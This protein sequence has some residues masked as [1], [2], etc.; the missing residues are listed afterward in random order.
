VESVDQTLPLW[1]YK[2]E[3][4]ALVLEDS[5]EPVAL[6]FSGG[7]IWTKNPTEATI[8]Q[9]LL[10]AEH[11]K[12][13]VRGDEFETYRTPTD[14]YLHP[15]DAEKY[16]KSRKEVERIIRSTRIKSFVFHSAVFGF[17]M[18]LILL[19]KHLGLVT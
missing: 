19:L 13:R 6:W 11:L 17:F 14:T 5:E 2:D 4:R 10:I 7:E 15:D 16:A 1:S 9:M 12:A 8:E 18:G 3:Q